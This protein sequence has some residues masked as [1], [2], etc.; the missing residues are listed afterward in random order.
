MLT[1]EERNLRKQG[2]RCLFVYK[3][4]QNWDIIRQLIFV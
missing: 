2:K 3:Y 1:A 4:G